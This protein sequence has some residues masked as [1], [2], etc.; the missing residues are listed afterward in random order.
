MFA[1]SLGSGINRINDNTVYSNRNF[2]PF[3]LATTLDQF[4]SGTD[5]YGDWDQGHIIDGS[6]VYI[7][8]NGDYQGTMELNKNFCFDNGINGLV[9]HKTTHENV[10][11]QVKK[12]IVF[13]NG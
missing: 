3:F 13:D 10:T 7:T 4:G 9:V 5:H 6:G 2:M 8:R 12:N 11:V 1:E